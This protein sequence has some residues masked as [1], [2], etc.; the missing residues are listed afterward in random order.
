MMRWR[1]RGQTM[2]DKNKRRVS[3]LLNAQ[4]V[5]HMNED[6]TPSS[7]ATMTSSSTRSIS[8][9]TNAHSL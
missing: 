7:G 2:K 9:S 8:S 1:F 4:T 3:M 5:Y 6:A